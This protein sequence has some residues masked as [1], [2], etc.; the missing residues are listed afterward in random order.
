L[1]LPPTVLIQHQP[2][3][4][5]QHLLAITLAITM[6]AI[7]AQL[8][9]ASSSVDKGIKV[10][11]VTDQGNLGVSLKSSSKSTKDS[12]TFYAAGT[13]TWG[14]RIRVKSHVSA[15]TLDGVE[16]VIAITEKKP[17]S[18]EEAKTEHD[19]SIVSLVFQN[20]AKTELDNTKVAIAATPASDESGGSPEA[21]IYYLQ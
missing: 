19:V 12:T 15:A 16:L 8:N 5:A 9:P 18:S 10:F 20:I 13:A 21:W 1:G 7:V 2:P 11:Y 14:G 4:Q 17:L 6:S 3:L